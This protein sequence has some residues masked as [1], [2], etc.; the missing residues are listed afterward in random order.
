MTFTLAKKIRSFPTD[1]SCFPLFSLSV[2]V[3]SLFL[4]FFIASLFFALFIA[5]I[6][7]LHNLQVTRV[8]LKILL[9]IYVIIMKK[10]F[11]VRSNVRLFVGCLVHRFVRL[12]LH[13]FVWSNC[14]ALNITKRAHTNVSNWENHISCTLSTYV[15]DG[16]ISNHP[17]PFFY[18]GF[19][20]GFIGVD[21]VRVWNENYPLKSWNWQKTRTCPGSSGTLRSCDDEQ[22]QNIYI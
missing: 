20:F 7:C 3:R 13:S 16:F 14:W 18:S 10:F 21:C 1:F 12:F 5:S 17:L 2:Y 15:I 9:L 6:I 22:K 8:I 4:I 11:L 19:Y